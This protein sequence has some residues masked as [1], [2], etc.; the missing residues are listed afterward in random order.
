MHFTN[1]QNVFCIS[2][3][4]F[5]VICISHTIW[6]RQDFGIQTVSHHLFTASFAWL[7]CFARRSVEKCLLVQIRWMCINNKYSDFI[8]D[9]TDGIKGKWCSSE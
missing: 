8:V 5:G 2:I 3:T 4:Y 6:A 7:S 1:L 9:N